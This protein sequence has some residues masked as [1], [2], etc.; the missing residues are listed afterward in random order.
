MTDNETSVRK[1]TTRLLIYGQAQGY[2]TLLLYPDKLAVV[3]FRAFRIRRLVAFTV[4]GVSVNLI[5][6][7]P[8][9]VLEFLGVGVLWTL[10]AGAIGYLVGEPTDR[11]VATK[12]AAGDGDVTIIPLDSIIRLE[13]GK[14]KR[15]QGGQY[16]IVATADGME[17]GFSVKVDKW[18]ADLA[19]A[20]TARGR[21]VRTTPQGMTVTPP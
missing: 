7:P 3:R 15:R 18:S 14:S 11:Q 5:P 13:T 10:A 20:L 2:T 8:H 9:T 6:T 19:N 12:V 17:Y 1:Q 21:E 16:L 4:V